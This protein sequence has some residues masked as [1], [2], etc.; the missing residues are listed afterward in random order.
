MP[1]RNRRRKKN[2][3]TLLDWVDERDL[4]GRDAEQKTA[5]HYAIGQKNYSLVPLLLRKGAD[6]NIVNPDNDTPLVMA[7]RAQDMQMFTYF[8]GGGG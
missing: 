1:L 2:I 8:V 7:V 4:N 6:P 3:R 5:L